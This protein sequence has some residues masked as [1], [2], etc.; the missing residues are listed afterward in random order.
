[1]RNPELHFLDK[2]IVRLPEGI[3]IQGLDPPITAGS[4]L[5]LEKTLEIP[6]IQREMRTGWGRRVY[7]LHRGKDLVFGYLDRDG[8]HHV[9]FAGARASG[10]VVPLQ[11]EELHR[12]SSVSGIAIPV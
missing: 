11:K 3:A 12:L 5:L 4:L 9:L 6:E 1:M 7:A 8:T 2:R 10:A